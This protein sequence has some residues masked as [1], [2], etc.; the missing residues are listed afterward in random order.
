MDKNEVECSVS[1]GRGAEWSG[2]E[3]GSVEPEVTWAV[4]KGSGE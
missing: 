1:K 4:A 2:V 3:R